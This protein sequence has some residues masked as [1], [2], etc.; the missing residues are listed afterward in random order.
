MIQTNLRDLQRKQSE[1]LITKL[2][3]K[4][5]VVMDQKY[6]KQAEIRQKNFDRIKRVVDRQNKNLKM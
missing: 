5:Q 2:N 1:D 6:M 4:S 3:H